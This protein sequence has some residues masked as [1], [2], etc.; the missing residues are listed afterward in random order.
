MAHYDLTLLRKTEIEETLLAM[1][2]EIPYGQITVKNLTDKLTIARKTFYHYYSS[3][4]LCLESLIDRII[5]DSNLYLIALPQN[6]RLEDLYRAQLQFWMDHRT[7]LTVIIRDN[8]SS[9]LIER[10]TLS[11]LREDSVFLTRLSTRTLACDEDVLF[12]YISGQISLLLKWCA[13]GFPRPLEEMVQKI[14]R[15]SYEPLLSREPEP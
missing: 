1:M 3:K 12:Y 15:L 11:I 7:F 5:L 2:Q 10:I 4:Q 6:A 8:L 13:E 14:L 9:L